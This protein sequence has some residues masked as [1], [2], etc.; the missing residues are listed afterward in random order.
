MLSFK[1]F[2]VLLEKNL[3][4]RGKNAE[5]HSEYV[6]SSR[7]V[8]LG[9][10]LKV[11][12][13]IHPEGT[14]L[15]VHKT[16]VVQGSRGPEHYSHVSAGRSKK[17]IK[18]PH[19]LIQKPPGQDYNHPMAQAFEAATAIRLHQAHG[20]TSGEH[21]KK[22]RQLNDT[23]QTNIKK[24]P[25]FFR[26]QVNRRA[27]NAANAFNQ[28]IQGKGKV[29]EINHITKKT[30]ITKV[31]SNVPGGDQANP[32]DIHVKF[33]SGEETG[34]SLKHSSK[35]TISNNSTASIDSRKHF[36]DNLN[37]SQHSEN[38]NAMAQH[39][40]ETFQSGTLEQ[41]KKHLHYL[42]KSDPDF[43]YHY[44]DA[45]KGTSTHYADMPHYSAINNAKSFTVKASKSGRSFHVYDHDG[46]HITSI[47]HRSKHG[48]GSKPEVLA[49]LGN[50]KPKKISGNDHV[51]IGSQVTKG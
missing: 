8:T 26:N 49:K 44:V 42:L 3:S 51:I 36:N 48:P 32:H 33:E 1:N 24:L 4:F 50:I 34:A 41:Q 23:Y 2:F 17:I 12:N 9:R 7:F 43:D 35:G 5:E 21:A 16:E 38:T 31:S 40:A 19:S 14:K 6:S 22:L 18:I 27:K 47:E 45:E 13:V 10:Q 37:L 30:P 29:V 46:N 25:F 28:S 39:H 11:G 15:K 20:L